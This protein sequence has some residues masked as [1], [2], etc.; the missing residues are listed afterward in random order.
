MPSDEWTDGA[1]PVLRLRGFCSTSGACSVSPFAAHLVGERRTRGMHTAPSDPWG[2]KVALLDLASILARRVMRLSRRL[3]S[4]TFMRTDQPPPRHHC[5]R[6]QRSREDRR[7]RAEEN[8]RHITRR[9]ERDHRAG[10]NGRTR[11]PGDRRPRR[12]WLESECGKGPERRWPIDSKHRES[13][14][15]RSSAE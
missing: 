4:S 10:R 6:N 13:V 3:P 7:R 1:F 2:S 14:A 12:C 11:A 15:G 5:P 9:A 8:R